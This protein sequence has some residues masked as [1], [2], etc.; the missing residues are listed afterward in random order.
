MTNSNNDNAMMNA[1][2]NPDSGLVHHQRHMAITFQ[3]ERLGCQSSCYYND[4]HEIQVRTITTT[5]ALCTISSAVV[6]F[7][8]VIIVITE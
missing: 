5:P 7:L 4:N 3:S 1:K 8:T 2:R 6:I